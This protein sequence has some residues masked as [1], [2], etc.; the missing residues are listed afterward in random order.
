MSL[1]KKLHEI[2]GRI[3]RLENEIDDLLAE[4]QINYTKIKA[5]KA[6]IARLKSTL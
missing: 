2:R 3:I 4:K 5:L 6:E 1:G